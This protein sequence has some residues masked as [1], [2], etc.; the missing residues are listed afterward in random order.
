[1]STNKVILLGNVGKAPEVKLFGDHQVAN[2]SV[3]TSERVKKDGEY[4]EH[5]EWHNVVIWDRAAI[6]KNI[7][8]GTKIYVEGTLRTRAWTDDAGNK[9]YRTDV[10]T[11]Y[12]ELCSPKPTGT[13]TE[14][15]PE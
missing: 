1:M 5:A 3:A 15:M 12:F 13:S 9:Q 6:V 14:D 11:Q 10:M 7:R 8:V 2:I 4:V